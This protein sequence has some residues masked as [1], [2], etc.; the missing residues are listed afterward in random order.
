MYKYFGRDNI[1][2][3]NIIACIVIKTLDKGMAEDHR[4]NN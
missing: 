3:Y 1:K 4:K 2:G